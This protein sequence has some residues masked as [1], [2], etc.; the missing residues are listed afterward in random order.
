M[1]WGI[2]EV[3]IKNESSEAGRRRQ[4]Q[5]DDDLIETFKFTVQLE[6]G[7]PYLLS[8]KAQDLLYVEIKPEMFQDTFADLEPYSLE[9]N[10]SYASTRSIP[11]FGSEMEELVEAITS[12]TENAILVFL[13]SNMALSFFSERFLQ[14]LWE[15][16]N[17]LQIMVIQVL[18]DL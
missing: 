15:L 13:G 10:P 7:D 11:V 8:R 1:G 16:I 17:T 5:D 18:F 9:L 14:Y 12:I 6:F 2:T 3:V 4:L